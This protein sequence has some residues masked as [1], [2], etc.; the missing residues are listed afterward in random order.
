MI[1]LIITYFNQ[2]IMLEKQINLWK[3][4]SPKIRNNFKFIIIDD[5]SKLKAIDVIKKI[6]TTNLDL[7]LYEI[8]EDIYC[9]IPGAMNLGSKVA[10]TKWLLHMDMDHTFQEKYLLQLVSIC[11]ISEENIVYKFNRDVRKNVEMY[12]K[13]PLGF[14][15]HPKLCLMTKKLYWDIGGFDEDFCGHYGRTDTSFFTR[16]AGK[17]KNVYLKH[18][19]LDM[20][21]DGDAPGINRKDLSFNTNLLQRKIKTNNWSNN[22]LRFT[23]EKVDIK[24]G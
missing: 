3:S 16:G 1:S 21:K 15:F 5:A 11:K 13:N 23:W 6:N 9:N 7:H 19:L 8:K 12:K 17:F 10:E 4:Y 2:D 24:W 18:I 14:K 20:D 22:I